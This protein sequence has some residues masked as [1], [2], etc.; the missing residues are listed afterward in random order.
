MR[1]DIAAGVK[2]PSVRRRLDEQGL[3]AIGSTP[4]ELARAVAEEMAMNKD[5]TARIGIV[6]Q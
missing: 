5:L 6:P 2:D 1:D 4:Q 3:D